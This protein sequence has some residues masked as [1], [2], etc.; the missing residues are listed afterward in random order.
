M[1][2]KI[3]LCLLLILLIL[4]GCKKGVIESGINND[5][6]SVTISEQTY[7]FTENN[8]SIQV[9]YPKID[10]EEYKTI[11]DMFYII[12]TYQWM[13]ASGLEKNYL[14]A[15]IEYDVMTFNEYIISVKFTGYYMIKSSA[16][17]VDVCF[18]AS[19]DLHSQKP[20]EIFDFISH[21]NAFER[22]QNDDLV[23]EYGGLKALS[24]EERSSLI[25]SVLT[26]NDPYRMTQVYIE[27][28]NLY[29]VVESPSHA[30]GD[31]AIVC[32]KN[33]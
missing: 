12:A 24:F 16:Y 33:P 21:K 11:N 9:S 13:E 15:V 5:T 8:C 14:D 7:L 4:S 25:A 17:P 27:N 23:I 29:F 3:L 19:F 31:Y 22:V 28:E 6:E 2:K 20:L 10:R 26:E 32:F 18:A 30:L 1:N